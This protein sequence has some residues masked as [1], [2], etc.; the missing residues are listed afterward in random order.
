MGVPGHDER[1]SEFARKLSLPII[2]VVL[3]EGLSEEQ[4]LE[5]IERLQP[6]MSVSP[7]KAYQ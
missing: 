1:D 2:P 3:P 7:E 6:V 5:F 4:K